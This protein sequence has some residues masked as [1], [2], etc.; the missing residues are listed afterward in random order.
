[1]PQIPL[2][3]P[4]PPSQPPEN[5]LPQLLRTPSGL[6]IIELQGTINTP[7]PS[8]SSSSSTTPVGK[9]VFPTYKP[10]VYGEDDTKWMK[11]VYFYV[12]ENQRMTGE[13]KKLGKPFAVIRRRERGD[14][15]VVMEGVDVE[16]EGEGLVGEELEIAEIVRWKIVFAMRPEPV[17]GDA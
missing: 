4:T 7:P 11:R 9:L 15:D 14:A 17:T 8:S 1:M 5:P 10:D 2:H 12:G 6:A 16:G 3:L 13:V